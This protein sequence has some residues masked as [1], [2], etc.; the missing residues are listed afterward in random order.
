VLDARDA[1]LLVWK[2]TRESL[3]LASLPGDEG[4]GPQMG[5]AMAA[6]DEAHLTR[7]HRADSVVNVAIMDHTWGW[8]L[9][10]R[11]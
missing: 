5:A 7:P 2:G 1:L 6:A 4:D 3:P 11:R 9:T 10:G 8:M